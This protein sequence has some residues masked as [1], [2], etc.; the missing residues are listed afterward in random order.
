MDSTS[1]LKLI[2]AGL[3]ILLCICISLPRFISK[4]GPLTDGGVHAGP[5][6]G[7]DPRRQAGNPRVPPGESSEKK[8][9]AAAEASHRT[10]ARRPP[11][12]SP[13]SEPGIPGL[14]LL[15]SDTGSG[16]TRTPTTSSAS[17]TLGRD[18]S[19]N[20]PSS[21]SSK[22]SNSLLIVEIL[23]GVSFLI[24]LT[25]LFIWLK[26]HSSDKRRP[27]ERKRDRWD[28]DVKIK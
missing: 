10:P 4:V 18:D 9:I 14:D 6:S 16:G 1:T 12:S 3:C 28:Y 19:S 7:G 13:V 5:P 15:P 11:E 22:S 27:K 23:I 20:S 2:V 26:V 24:G 25:G 8:D 17:D 21:S